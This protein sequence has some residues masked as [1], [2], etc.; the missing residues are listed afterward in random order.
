MNYLIKII[1]NKIPRKYLIKLSMFLRPFLKVFYKGNKYTDPI[2]NSNYR[3]FL[4]YGYNK[5]R[6]NALCPGTLSLERHRFLWL[7]LKNETDYFK[8]KYKV[9]HIAPE[10]ILFKKFNNFKNW[11]Y[12]TLDLFSPLAKIKADICDIPIENNKFDLVICNHVLE[13]VL[14]DRKALSEIY[15]VLKVGGCAILQV[16]VDNSIEKTHE[17][18]KFM[19]KSQRTKEFGQYDHIR[20]Y[21]NDFYKLIKSVGFNVKAIDYLKKIDN[22]LKIK[23]CLPKNEKIPVAYKI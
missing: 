5:I 6:E 10:Q 15:R 4:P 20:S 8:K 22:D 1:L 13:H 12:T 16:P 21:G 2:D 9:L 17:N 7:Y 3:K 19:T 14:D 11:D 18:K 23:Y